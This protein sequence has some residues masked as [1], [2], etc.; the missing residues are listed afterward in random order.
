MR[1]DASI[2]LVDYDGMFVPELAGLGSTELGHRN[3]QHPK[4]GAAHFGPYLDNF[5]VWLICHSVDML[6]EDPSLWSRFRGGEEC[7]LFRE[8]DLRDPVNS[9]LFR[10]LEHHASDSVRRMSRQLRFLLSL[11]VEEVPA[12]GSELADESVEPLPPPAISSRRTEQPEWVQ[13]ANARF[14]E[15]SIKAR[16]QKQRESSLRKNF[17]VVIMI[18]IGGA[19]S[20]LLP[21]MLPQFREANANAARKQAMELV[22]RADRWR[23]DG[24]VYN[25]RT[26]DGGTTNMVNAF[27]LYQQALP[28][29]KAS[30]TPEELADCYVGLA[31]CQLAFGNFAAAQRSADAALEVA[32]L[33]A[34]VSDQAHFVLLRAA[35]ATN[36]QREM[37]VHFNAMSPDAG[38]MRQ[39]S[40]LTEKAGTAIAELV[41]DEDPSLASLLQQTRERFFA[42]WSNLLTVE[43]YKSLVNVM[44]TAAPQTRN[45]AAVYKA[46]LYLCADKPELEP[47]RDN[48]QPKLDALNIAPR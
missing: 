8:A 42:N 6:I 45:S 33:P 14:I 5:A 2:R 9:E 15:A 26:G 48:I 29:L 30:G 17:W 34:D 4:R 3:F 16:S 20:T 21:A 40:M 46:A 11:A 22:A 36:F 25:Y 27:R 12:F 32:G 44:V 31:E 1:G 13:E 47:L 7:L 39:Y 38:A 18:V 37:L 24:A 41:A 35:S 10:T 23:V 19:F 28:M 43:A